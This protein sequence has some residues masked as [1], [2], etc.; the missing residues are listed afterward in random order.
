MFK[1]FITLI[2]FIL[3]FFVSSEVNAQPA[4]PGIPETP[5]DGGIVILLA[6][7]AAYGIKKL[8]E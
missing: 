7:G 5:I 6:A 8:R 1:K 3:L 4:P 2:I